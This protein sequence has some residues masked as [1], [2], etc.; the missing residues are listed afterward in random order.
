MRRAGR[1]LEG[2]IAHRLSRP[3]RA[4]TAL[5][6]ALERSTGPIIDLLIRLWLAKVFFVS[7]ILKIFGLGAGPAPSMGTPA[8]YDAGDLGKP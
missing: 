6:G 7:G 5:H 3:V 2:F 8:R 4:I 1:F